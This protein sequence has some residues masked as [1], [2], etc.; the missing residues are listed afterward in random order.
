MSLINLTFVV[1]VHD[2]ILRQTGVGRAGCDIGKLE[3]V[4]GRIEQQMYYNQVEDLFEIAAWFGIAISKG[5]AFVD[6]NKRTGLAVMLTFLEI[7]G[8]SIQ[9]QTGLDDL[10]VEIAEL[11]DEHEILANK[12]SDFLYDLSEI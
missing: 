7:Q 1:A 10:M 2:E 12:V 6:G 8:V 11:Q 4:L 5:H 9:E 3:S